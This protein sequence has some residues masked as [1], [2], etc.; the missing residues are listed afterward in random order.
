[1]VAA[2][3]DA[4]KL[5]EVGGLSEVVESEY[6]YH[7][8]LRIPIDPNAVIG[9]D[10]NGNDVTLRYA[11]ATQQYNAELTAW[12]DAAEVVWSEGF[13]DLDLAPIFG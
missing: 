4:V 5:L 8:I 6:G 2:F 12:T 10:A 7:I 11:A 1:M 9:T 3:E 13:E